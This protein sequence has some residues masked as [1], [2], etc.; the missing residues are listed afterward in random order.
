MPSYLHPGVYIEEVPSAVKPIEGVGTS[1]AAFIGVAK[2]GPT[3]EAVRITS[4]SQFQTH[5]G[6][7]MTGSDLAYA[8]FGFFANGGTAC[9]VVRVNRGNAEFATATLHKM[10]GEPS[11]ELRSVSPGGWGNDLRIGINDG[12][13]V[14]EHEFSLSVYEGDAE[15]PV[16]LH[17]DLSMNDT[18]PNYALKVINQASNYIFIEEDLG[19]V[20]YASFIS[21]VDISGGVNLDNVYN[22][23]LV[24]DGAENDFTI[25]LRVEGEPTTGVSP[26]Q[27]IGRIN[28]VMMPVFSRE[29]AF[30]D[31]DGD[32]RFLR[33]K[34]PSTGANSS[35]KILPPA[36]ADA[37]A[38]ILG[39]MEY[40]W[41]F[42]GGT[43]A[44]SFV[45]VRGEAP[46][47]ISPQTFLAADT[48]NIQL[49]DAAVIP[50]T[51]FVASDG[52]PATLD[53]IITTISAA[54][55]S[56]DGLLW[57]DGN[58]LIIRST[59]HKK[60]TVS[61]DAKDKLFADGSK[62]YAYEYRG[63]ADTAATI[64]SV[65]NVAGTFDG[66][67]G[68]KLRVQFD[69]KPVTEID[70]STVPTTA[71]GAEPPEIL[72]V[73]ITQINEQVKEQ[74]GIR[75]KVAGKSGDKLVLTS[76]T[77]GDDSL[78]VFYHP[79]DD[80]GE[81]VAASEDLTLILF[82]LTPLAENSPITVYAEEY[83][84]SPALIEG[85]IDLKV[86]VNVSALTD[87]KLRISIS[88]LDD[89]A[90]KAISL[91]G[92]DIY[93]V[94]QN[95]AG[96]LSE[97]ASS[98]ARDVFR[99][100]F[101]GASG[102][103]AHLHMFSVDQGSDAYIRLGIPLSDR[104]T[105]DPSLANAKDFLF[106]PPDDTKWGNPSP[107]TTAYSF[108]FA[109][110][111]RRPK[112]NIDADSGLFEPTPL[113]GGIHNDTVELKD[114]FGEEKI[115]D[116]DGKQIP[117][118]LHLLD[119]VD[120]VSVLAIPC[121]PPRACKVNHLDLISKA[122]AH[123]DNRR[124]RFYIAD[125]PE[126]VIEPNHAKIF[127]RDDLKASKGRDY[128]AIYYP[129]VNMVDPI[130]TVSNVRRVPISGHMAGMY[131]RIDGRR[132]VWKAP[133]GLEAG[134]AES[135]SLLYKVTDVDQ[136]TLNPIGLNCIR[137]FPGAGIVSWGARTLG[138][139]T[140]PEWKYVSI[141]RTAIM[142]R[143]S[144]YNGI[145]WAVFEPNDEPLWAS[146]RLNI[147]AF[148][149]GLFRAGAFQGQK[150]SDAYFVRCGLGDTMTQADIDRGQVIVQVGFAPLKP[151]EFVIIRIEQIVGQ[152]S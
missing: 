132:G 73:L 137:Q 91:T 68:R 18:S 140:A 118:G 50:V 151:A 46:L 106:M 146:L 124:D 121:V 119:A 94:L 75:K 149:N 120:E 112:S 136:D 11:L 29:V 51:N 74:T 62:L 16:E 135:N 81:P 2:K 26:E 5:F 3:D 6:S 23:R 101:S 128:A 80:Y 32:K 17:T 90:T 9:Y 85:N 37:T 87:K 27:I 52:D 8:V 19:G 44:G 98:D 103:N 60:I 150:V 67:S 122:M 30:L 54:S 139:K 7:F 64:E 39:L 111:V 148:M 83:A 92:T 116:R 53:S 113:K 79:R 1:T 31:Q 56:L 28:E 63:T 126:T 69:N 102:A 41:E 97:D 25:D 138:V 72:E 109:V 131:A 21:Q 144:I 55:S 24:I 82:G 117:A 147:G 14:P 104:G 38:E 15:Q 145:Q 141:R 61:G 34:S 114:I 13:N 12:N 76:P 20:D 143:K 77:K 123:C 130:G 40:S 66:I 129:W 142:L 88:G 110:G 47:G 133:A 107:I 127:V 58:Y 105:H 10:D 48:L 152:Q 49:D 57:T 42:S 36:D 59:A 22:L 33:L 84:K 70:L 96:S 4:W 35:I 115:A 134:L 45:E 71:G 89:A 93:S 86:P 65:A 125:V 99:L 43:N 108:T 95:L 78:I 100:V